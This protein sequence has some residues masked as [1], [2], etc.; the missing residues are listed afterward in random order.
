MSAKNPTTRL[1]SGQP[2]KLSSG[3]APLP[4]SVRP[5]VAYDLVMLRKIGIGSRP[6]TSDDASPNRPTGVVIEDADVFNL[7]FLFTR[8]PQEAAAIL[9]AGVEAFRAAALEKVAMQLSTATIQELM[10]QVEK[11][12][13]NTFS[14]LAAIPR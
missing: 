13:V 2:A 5:M 8:P 3:K 6:L 4:L 7:V 14:Q 1:K 11:N 12:L 9:E 10:S